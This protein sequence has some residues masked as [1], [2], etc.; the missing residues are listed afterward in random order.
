MCLPSLK[1]A[2][3]IGLLLAGPPPSSLTM[4]RGFYS[5]AV[6]NAVKKR[7]APMIMPAVKNSRTLDKIK[8]HHSGE[9]GAITEHT[10][11]S[12]ND[13]ATFTLVIIKRS[14]KKKQVSC[15]RHRIKGTR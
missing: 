9:I 3:Q 1:C 8:Q 10:I 14:K 6:I 4:D 12:G 15:R 13:S 5:V 2:L 11:S 7:G